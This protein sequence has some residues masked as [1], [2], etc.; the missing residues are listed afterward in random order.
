MVYGFDVVFF[1]GVAVICLFLFGFGVLDIPLCLINFRRVFCSA[2]TTSYSMLIF[3]K[4]VAKIGTKIRLSAPQSH[5]PPHQT[6]H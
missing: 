5:N 1:R 2:Y 3:I 6:T 4:I